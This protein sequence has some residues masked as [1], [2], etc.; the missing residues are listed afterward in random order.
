MQTDAKKM[1]ALS[2]Q[3]LQLA[4]DDLLMHLRFLDTALG[5]LPWRERAKIGCMATDG[6]VCYYDPVYILKTYRADSKKISRI[7]LHMLLHCVFAHSFMYDKME[8]DLWDLSADIAVENV[9]LD[10]RLP[11]VA[12]EDDADRERKLK[13]LREDIGPLTAERVYRYLR[14]NPPTPREREELTRL[15]YQDSHGLWKPAEN[16]EMT[17]EQWK[18]ISE[19]VRADLKSFTKARSGTET[20]EKNLEETTRDRYDYTDILR[21]FMVTAEDMTVNDEEFDYIYYTYGL[22]H[23]GNLPLIEPLEYREARKVKEFAIAID[24]SASCRGAVVRAFLQKTYSILK[25]EENFFHK[26]NIHIL[27]CD[28]EVQSDTKITNDEDFEVFMQYGKLTGFGATDFRPVFTYLDALRD[29]GEFENLK[30]LIYFTDGYG[31]YPER[32]PDY[33]VIFA[34]VNED[35]N[36][37]PVPPW[38][39]KVVLESEEL[40]D[41]APRSEGLKNDVSGSEELEGTE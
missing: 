17:V 4:H 8:T 13:I 32:M 23:Y 38:S 2:N 6:A 36:R 24:T 14:H 12:L 34:F 27:Q 29:G 30:G 1:A 26:V 11:G 5:E 9:I 19:R 22:E 40:E 3:I 41:D 21:R 28:N 7:Y 37:A 31:I 33:D 20:L 16:L 15:F 39:L 18:K 35:E 25:S 10:L